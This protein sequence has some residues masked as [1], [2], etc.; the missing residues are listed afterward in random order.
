MLK[1]NSVLFNQNCNPHI[2]DFT[3]K[4]N[5]NLELP[6]FEEGGKPLQLFSSYHEQPNL[7]ILSVEQRRKK[8][9]VHSSSTENGSKRELREKDRTP[10]INIYCFPDRRLWNTDQ[11][12]LNGCS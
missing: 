8:L 4:V 1:L 3:W 6:V 10:A 2:G 5:S 9:A 7:N 11:H 12:G